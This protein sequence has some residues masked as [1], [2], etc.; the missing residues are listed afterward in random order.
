[1]RRTQN[2]FHSVALR[3]HWR[4]HSISA[5]CRELARDGDKN[6]TTDQVPNTP[7]ARTAIKVGK[8]KGNRR[9]PRNLCSPAH[10]ATRS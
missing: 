6:R 7:E 5:N 1:M 3:C 2:G 9:D 4:V 10:F 8:T